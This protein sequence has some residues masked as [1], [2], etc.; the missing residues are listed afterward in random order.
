[1]LSPNRL[2]VSA[3]IRTSTGL[4]RVGCEGRSEELTSS[5][6]IHF[7]LDRSINLAESAVPAGN[8]GAIWSLIFLIEDESRRTIGNPRGSKVAAESLLGNSVIRKIS[9]RL[10]AD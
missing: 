9:A 10:A 2:L 5:S 7:F 3:G 6:T 4:F 1:M 8:N